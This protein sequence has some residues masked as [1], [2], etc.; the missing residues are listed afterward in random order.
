MQVVEVG[1]ALMGEREAV[2]GATWW[3]QR[4]CRVKVVARQRGE[5]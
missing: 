4:F 2:W 5:R 3:W 1:G